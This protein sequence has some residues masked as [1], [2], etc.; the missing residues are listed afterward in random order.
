MIELRKTPEFERW[1]DGLRDL[2]GRAR[3]Q[4]RLHRLRQGHLG[5]NKHVGEAVLELRIHAGPGYRVYV[6]RRGT[7]V[8][9]VLAG[10]DKSSQE[11]DI[12]F[13]QKLAS[14]L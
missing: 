4:R 14:N 7:A 1:L 12:R 13:A 10:G 3:I 5:D 9:I 8:V 2:Q 11:K 6:T